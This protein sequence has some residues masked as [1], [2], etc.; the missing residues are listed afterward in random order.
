MTGKDGT[1]KGEY[2]QLL[3][4]CPVDYSLKVVGN[5]EAALRQAGYAIVVSG[6]NC[7]DSDRSRRV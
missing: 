5:A 7:G 1:I 2:E 6:M 4:Y 3:Y